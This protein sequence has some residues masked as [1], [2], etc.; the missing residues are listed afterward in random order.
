MV[1]GSIVPVDTKRR[2]KKLLS[3]KLVWWVSVILTQCLDPGK[4]M[5]PPPTCWQCVFAIIYWQLYRGLCFKGWCLNADARDLS[6]FSSNSGVHFSKLFWKCKPLVLG[7]SFLPVAN[8]LFPGPETERPY[9]LYH[10]WIIKTLV[11]SILSDHPLHQPQWD[12]ELT[13]KTF[14]LQEGYALMMCLNLLSGI[15]STRWKSLDSF[16]KSRSVFII[17]PW[18]TTFPIPNSRLMVA[19]LFPPL[20]G[21]SYLSPLAGT[22]LD[23]V[24]IK[25]IIHGSV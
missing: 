8:S 9:G 1:L 18:T 15:V 14:F 13:F 12:L 6:G 7:V 4:K 16:H 3:E 23:H 10:W 24:P 25:R 20:Q 5:H 21:C 22:G 11:W 19:L 2:K 17:A